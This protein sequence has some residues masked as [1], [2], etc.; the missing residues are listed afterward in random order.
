MAQPRSSVRRPAARRPG[1]LGRW[2]A[3]IVVAMCAIVL[4]ACALALWLVGSSGEAQITR[5]ERE[6][7]SIEL[8]LLSQIQH[9]EG[10]EVLIRS[11]TRLS[12]LEGSHYVY[13]LKDAQGQMLAGDLDTWPANLTANEDWTPVKAEGFE[14]DVATQ[15]LDHGLQLMVGRDRNALDVF[16]DSVIDSVWLAIA[17]VAVTCLL[18]GAA[19]TSYMLARVR[20]LSH[21]AARVTAGDFSARAPGA[22][23][24]GPF[25][26]IALAQNT[27][28][29]RIEDL[30]TGLRTVTDSLAHDLRTPMARMRRHIEEGLVAP[31]AD[32]KN[33][34]MDAALADADSALSTFTALI[35]IARA[36]GGLSRDAMTE[37][38]LADLLANVQS[39]FEPLAEDRNQTLI[40]TSH[41]ARILGHKPLLMQ[42]VSN[43]VHNAIKYAP[44]G[45]RIAVALA[46]TADAIEITVTDNGPGIPADQREQALQRFH[47][48]S[49]SGDGQAG[50]LGLGLAIVEACA[51]LHRGKLVLEDAGPGLRARLVLAL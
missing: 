26:E 34:A 13:A 37:V 44:E 18:A 27:M 40:V 24:G 31:T 46:T 33:T 5:Q 47:R 38:D 8:D 29:D 2:S 16:Q 43:L 50:G 35:D 11:V 20:A 23:D 28:L 7:A 49:S 51:R 3:L 9:D 21:V 30:V 42:A 45:G 10:D 48:L 39:L 15:Q 32:A 17:L 12:L 4:A 36:D 25:G 22:G 6:T 41:P 1:W 14:M 19:I